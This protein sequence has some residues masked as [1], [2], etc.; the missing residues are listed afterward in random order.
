LHETKFDTDE[1]AFAQ[2]E[3]YVKCGYVVKFPTLQLAKEYV[4]GD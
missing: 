2:I 1:D 3:K 4:G